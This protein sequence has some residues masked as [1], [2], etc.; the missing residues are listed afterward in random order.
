MLTEEGREKIRKKVQKS[1]KLVSGGIRI[2]DEQMNLGGQVFQEWP[3]NN[4]AWGFANIRAFW[5]KI[6]QKQNVF[7]ARWMDVHTA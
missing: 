3:V 2:M 5:D 7:Q 4:R 1:K 6:Y